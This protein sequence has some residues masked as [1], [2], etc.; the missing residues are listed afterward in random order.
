MVVMVV[1]VEWLNGC[2]GY[3]CCNGWRLLRFYPQIARR[4]TQIF[5]DCKAQL[6]APCSIQHSKFNIQN[7]FSPVAPSLCRFVALSPLRVIR[8]YR[9]VALV[10]Q[11][12]S[13]VLIH[14]IREEHNSS[15]C[16]FPQISMAFSIRK[17]FISSSDTGWLRNSTGSV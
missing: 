7:F 4:K 8:D 11:S 2:N 16:H 9:L 3:R 17:V 12:V 6:Q 10:A 5:T 1:M 14:V 15:K 13:S